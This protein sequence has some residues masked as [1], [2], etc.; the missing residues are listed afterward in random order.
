M[1]T[2]YMMVGLPGSGKT[3][4]ANQLEN[5]TVHS[6]DAIRA[7][8][9]GDVTDQSQQNLVFTTLHNRVVAD[10]WHGKN[11]VYDAT[12]INYRQRM[13]F[14]KW[15]TARRIPNLKTVCVF[16]ATP[17]QKCLEQNHS[18][19]RTIPDQVITRMYKH[20]DVPMFAEGWDEIW[21]RNDEQFNL[22]T[23]MKRLAT[24]EHDNPH[25]EFTVGQHLLTAWSYFNTHYPEL[26]GSPLALATYLHDI[27]K[28]FTKVFEDGGGNPSENA[29][30]YHHENVGAYDSFSYTGN[31]DTTKR[32]MVALLIRW[33][34][35]PYTVDKSENPIKTKKRLLSLIGEDVYK[36]LLILHECDEQAH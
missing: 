23:M 31:L 18:R 3:Y 9:L 19:E 2:L 11:T 6:S 29:H 8:I 21:I 27:G 30:Y 25:H 22:D 24:I 14:L 13:Q 15:L 36:D 5:V 7:E 17:Y 4:Y 28:E 32:L 1:P 16:L 35:Y 10:L 33:H 34:M 26:Y 12:N 20:F